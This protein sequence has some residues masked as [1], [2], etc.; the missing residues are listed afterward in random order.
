MTPA[1]PYENELDFL[2]FRI[3]S[4]YIVT[5][6]CTCNV[7]QKSKA[8]LISSQSD[9]VKSLWISYYS[10][11]SDGI[12]NAEKPSISKHF[13]ASGVTSRWLIGSTPKRKA[14]C[15]NH[16]GDAISKKCEGHFS[17]GKT[18]FAFFHFEPIAKISQRM[19][20]AEFLISAN[21]ISLPANEAP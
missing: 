9:G 3:T 6:T 13:L 12:G 20:L 5:F 10:V 2:S 17:M 21:K 7:R 1:V 15:S 19:P 16:I 18:I 8:L 14:V 11:V 4:S